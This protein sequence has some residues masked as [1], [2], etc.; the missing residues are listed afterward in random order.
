[1]RNELRV[2]QFHFRITK[3]VSNF[4]KYGGR[5][6]EAAEGLILA[7]GDL[8]VENDL[9]DMMIKRKTWGLRHD[10]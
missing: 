2:R 4:V 5:P 3:E 8:A 6:E 7:L 1:M 9:V 10:G